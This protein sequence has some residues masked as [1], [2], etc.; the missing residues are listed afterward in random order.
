VPFGSLEDANRALTVFT[1][2]YNQRPQAE[3][4]GL[5]PDQMAQLLYGDWVGHGALLLNESL[6]IEELGSVAFLADARTLLAYIRDSGPVKATSAHNL[7]RAVIAALLPRLRMP[8][9]HRVT[10]EY[11]LPGPVN[12]AD[13]LWL[14]PL[15]HVSMFAGLLIR[16]KGFR[17]TARGSE[18]L[19]DDRAG[20]LYALLFRTLFRTLDL[21]A[22]GRDDRHP[23]LQSTVA[24]SFYKLR[25]CAGD[26]SSAESLAEHAWLASAKEPPSEWEAAN[27]DFRHYAFRHRVLDPL[28]QFGL[29]EERGLRTDVRWR[30][31]VEYRTTPLFPRF[32]RFG[33]RRVGT[34]RFGPSLG[35]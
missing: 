5:S 32:L 19:S 35:H 14:S 22:L 1:D 30:D 15:R 24:Y 26:W 12:E 3:L 29:M 8:V 11:G 18:L 6:T 33:F 34:G 13:V 27:V 7:P 10:V 20:E 2:E 4:G 31:S 21:R 25:E 28:T 16:R 17:V 23:G 9:Q